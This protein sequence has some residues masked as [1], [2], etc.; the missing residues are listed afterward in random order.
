LIKVGKERILMNYTLYLIWLTVIFL[1]STIA[2][3]YFFLRSK[4]HPNRNDREQ[5]FYL[6]KICL[7]PMMGAGFLFL[8]IIVRSL[9]AL[10]R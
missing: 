5:S 2:S 9:A 6:G 3:V 10:S 4:W 7:F 1:L 8:V